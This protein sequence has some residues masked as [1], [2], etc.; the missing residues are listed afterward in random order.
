MKIINES[1]SND[2]SYEDPDSVYTEIFI[3]MKL[4][5]IDEKI[6][7]YAD[8]IKKSDI[9]DSQKYLSE[10]EVLRRE[11]QKL[12]NYIYNKGLGIK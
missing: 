2:Y 3:N 1:V 5:S 7:K 11:K 9:R 4:Y 12:S 8:L 10:I 6:N